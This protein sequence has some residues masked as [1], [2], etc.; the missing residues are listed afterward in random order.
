[1]IGHQ[2]REFVDRVMDRKAIT[3]DDLVALQHDIFVDAV[4][5][6]DDIDVLVALDRA[7]P[8]STAGFAHW[9]TATVVDFAVWE[10]RP[11]GVI[12]REKA[13]WLIAT[14]TGGEGPTATARRI[15]FEVVREAQSCDELLVGFAM[16]RDSVPLR[17]AA[18]SE[19]YALAS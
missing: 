18:R 2:L 8:V 14:L 11:T 4:M 10:S 19:R 17:G 3:A 16:A 1:M 13:H 9:L 5:T 6:R 15:A 7:V 12:D